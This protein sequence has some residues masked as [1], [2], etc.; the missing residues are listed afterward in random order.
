MVSTVPVLFKILRR[1]TQQSENKVSENKPTQGPSNSKVIST[2]EKKMT[3][4]K[5]TAI[6]SGKPVQKVVPPPIGEEAEKI[7][8][9]V[10]TRLEKA[11]HPLAHFKHITCSDNTCVYCKELILNVD[12]TLCVGHKPCVPGRWYPH[13]GQTLWNQLRKKHDSGQSYTYTGKPRENAMPRLAIAQSLMCNI[14]SVTHEVSQ[15]STSEAPPA[16]A[17]ISEIANMDTS[18]PEAEV[19]SDDDWAANVTPDAVAKA[20][21]E[22]DKEELQRYRML[23]ASNQLLTTKLGAKRTGISQNL[24]K[25][26]NKHSSSQH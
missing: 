14:N 7:Y 15:L 11:R 13:V 26:R 1:L 25:K 5:P 6:P 4:S 16:E 3:K 17:N 20:L 23:D 12:L 2:P 21:A 8:T 24:P 9:Q 10:M 19:T 18:A 22:R